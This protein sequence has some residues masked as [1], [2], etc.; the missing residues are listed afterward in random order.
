MCEIRRDG[1]P[2]GERMARLDNTR[3]A[4]HARLRQMLENEAIVFDP[5]APPPAYHLE[6]DASPTVHRI[7]TVRPI[8]A[9]NVV[10]SLAR[11]LEAFAK[12]VISTVTQRKATRVFSANLEIYNDGRQVWISVWADT[13]VP[14]ASTGRRA[15]LRM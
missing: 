4:F 2:F 15:R 14:R 8:D 1:A 3:A 9:D 5:D 13:P 10:G 11:I 7:G 6:R 12:E